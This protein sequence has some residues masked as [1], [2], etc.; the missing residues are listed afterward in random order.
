M[1]GMSYP[2]NIVGSSINRP[3]IVLV[4]SASGFSGTN[5]KC[6]FILTNPNHPTPDWIMEGG[7]RSL[8]VDLGT[9]NTK[10][11]AFDWG[12]AQ[13]V[14]I[15]DISI[16]ARSGFA[17]FIGIG[18][19]NQLLSNISVNGGQYGLYLPNHNEAINWG[20]SGE[21]CQSSITGCNFTN[22][23]VNA[24]HLWGYGGIT[25]SGITIQQA[26]GVAIQT[27][28]DGYS[29]VIQFPFSLFDS[30]ITFTSTNASNVAISN[31]TH[32]NMAI[33]G[34]FV[35]GAG[36]VVDNGGDENL[37][38]FTPITSWTHVARFNYVDKAAR[39][40]AQGGSYA[41]VNYNANGG[42]SSNAAVVQTD[43]TA[44][45][46]DLTSKHIWAKT[47]SFEDAGA[48]LVPAGSSAAT[49][50][51]AINAYTEVFLAHGTYNLS[52]PINLKA[53]SI[54]C[55]CP[56]V[57]VCGSIL[58]NSFTPSS[59][60]WLITTDNNATATTYMM[61]IATET[62]N[63]NFMGS[64]NWMAGTN[65]I[66][67]SNLLDHGYADIEPNMVRLNF[68]GNGG[69]RVFNYQDEKAP[70][71]TMSTS[72]RKVRVTGTSQK[73]TFY[74]LNLERGGGQ[75][76][77]SATPM[78]EITNASKVRVFGAK[79]EAF[80]P[81]ATITN[82]NDIFLTNICDYC[83]NGYGTTGANQIEISGTNDKIELSNLMWIGSPAASWKIVKD[84]W[85]TN[86]PSRQANHIGVY[87]YNWS[88]ISDVVAAIP[89]TSVSVSPTTLALNTG[90]TG[91][92]TATVLPANAT[93][94]T[95][96]WSTS[97]SAVAIVSSTGLVT[98]VAAGTTTI[99]VTT[100]NGAKTATC[101]VTVTFVN[102]PVTGVSVSPTTVSL[103]IAGT[104]QLTA[105][106]APANATNKTVTWSSSNT[107]I[108]TVS[109]SGL[110][111][112]VAAGN[113]TI[114]VTTQDGSFTATT[115]ITIT[116][117]PVN[118]ALNKT[119]TAS[120]VETGNTVAMGNDGSTTTRWCSVDGTLNQWWKVDLGTTSSIT[121]TEIDWEKNGAYKYKIEVSTD[122]STWT[123]AVDKTTNAT[124]AAIMSD[125]FIASARYIRIT[126]TG[127]PSGYW[128]SFFEFKVWGST[129]NVPVTGV[130]VS[131][132][133]ASIVA[134]ATSQLTATV[135]PTTATDKTVIWSSG[136]TSVATVNSSGLVSAVAVGTSTITATTQ[137]GSFTATSAITVTA[138]PIAVTSVSV[139][140]TTASIVAGGTSQLTA[141]VLP[142]N[143]TNK[144]VT[145]SSGNT[146]IAIVNT[147]GLVTAI[148]AG[149]ATI[150]ATT[151][152][153][154]KTAT[155]AVT[156]AAANVAVT[157]VSLSPATVSIGVA[158]TS[159]LT[160]TVIPS[161]ATNKTISW[162]SGNTAVATVST[163]GLVTG[164]AAGT[165]T[166]TVTTQDGSFT[167]T[168]T[169]TVTSAPVNIALN[170]T[171]TA[172]TFETGNTVANG[173]DGNTTTRWCASSGALNEWWKVDLGTTASITGT[174]ID[175]EKNGAYKYKI[176][177]STDNSTWTMAVD[178]TTNSTSAQI[179]TDNFTASARYVRITVAGLP[180]GYWTSFFEF[181]VWGSSA[182]V[183]V[184]GVSI[185]PPTTSIVVGAT[186]QLA[187]T[188][189]PAT[190]TN[191]TVT[192][193]SGNTS[194]AT[195]N[196]GGL[197]TA[198]AVGTST[199]TATTQDG[200]F[201]A[202]S[203][204]TVTA[205]PVAVTSVSVSTN[206]AS[207]VAGGTIQL[208]ATVLPSNA[209]NK[210]VTWSSGNTAAA[211][212]NTSGLV[213]GV[214]AGTATITVTTQDGG[215]TA[216]CA[217]TVTVPACTGTYIPYTTTAP[218][219][220]QSIDA[221]WTNAPIGTIT[222]VTAGTMPSDF[223]GTHWRTMYDNTKLYILVEVKDAYKY[224]DSGTAWW[225]D[226]V[227]E[228][229]IDGNNS[230]GTT[231][232]GVNDFQ[233]AFR[234]N[235]ATVE[236]GGNSV[237][238][239]TGIQFAQQAVTGG[240]NMEISIPWTTIGVTPIAGNLMGFDIAVGDDDNGGVRDAQVTA[241]DNT[242]NAYQNP[243]TFGTVTL[244]GTALKS[245]LNYATSV[246]KLTNPVDYINLS[247]NPASTKITVELSSFMEKETIM[248]YST[249]GR[250]VK[251]IN[252]LGLIQQVDIDD[253]PNG[254]YIVRLSDHPGLT[255]KF[256]KQ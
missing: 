47:P 67:R 180:S 34:L 98:A 51:A 93:N 88:T 83:A 179:M 105:T 125:N 37:I 25:M 5:P 80:Q 106:A 115:T 256:I 163:S 126:V 73:L 107:A 68:S 191:K 200:G 71:G 199:I 21:I 141:T 114:T 210:T 58:I 30:K 241:F 10:A 232:D 176:E 146:A 237:T 82:C 175:W 97:D 253:L 55:G 110:V 168:C 185:S 17:G 112:A 218:I 224:N 234:Y 182:N 15:E 131:P 169:V 78:L 162:I 61:D 35:T 40:D 74:G 186:S 147:S 96:S 104:N 192:W 72:F 153:G 39:N 170:K 184:T 166:I 164:V 221:I 142:A 38:G 137:Y 160:A 29:P 174:E 207:I 77:V 123:M 148:A 6:V 7:I 178:K 145:W 211:T 119:A 219:I 187:A 248:I 81:Y 28:Y 165:A 132:V 236:L 64:V 133:T 139:S 121:G 14:Y 24:L 76:P 22:Q 57:G 155:C 220:D 85:N 116:S 251:K 42:S 56:G 223:A 238:R 244:C 189:A 193:T 70:G 233:L 158:S 172:S 183:P 144:T 8:N 239:T 156:V 84:P 173:N 216:T 87:H 213:T 118:I 79:T 151:Q 204:I 242:G 60:T 135:A 140:P 41:G 13:Y 201:S 101:A 250:F 44:P 240:Y 53:N 99:T 252:V 100:Q 177:V 16:E 222:H 1:N 12:C 228:I 196:S 235:D 129:A 65:S 217:V 255:S 4:N 66:F 181:K 122:N 194:A 31:T 136:N 209:T 159:Q 45:P 154:A 2:I 230:K 138:A 226:D 247:P 212:V 195:V 124:S 167:A 36:V 89:V 190:A 63:I 69:G 245:D 214:A 49:I 243:S 225:D 109:A 149:T 9:G 113:A 11:V 3:N 92:L 91:Q 249:N 205:A 117:A 52:A 197:V 143:A 161:N 203:A 50:Q 111:T 75:Y 208:T 130:S 94:K 171:A 198:V 128:T 59:A 26:S 48:Y 152:D 215:Y 254:M 23:S 103:G 127:L 46:S 20:I 120:S 33:N 102:V 157:G 54:F 206:T 19:A 108:A 95:I 18:G 62:T 202:T 43:S 231:Y 86:T 32:M 134:G 227:V 90:S 188:V 229:Y 27:V 150:T 246:V